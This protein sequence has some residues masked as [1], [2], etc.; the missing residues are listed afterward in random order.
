MESEI[1]FSATKIWQKLPI[2]NQQ[3]WKKSLKNPSMF[4]WIIK[5]TNPV[6]QME[7]PANRY[8]LFFFSHPYFFFGGNH[9]TAEGCQ[10]ESLWKRELGALFKEK[11]SHQHAV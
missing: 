1:I 5:H 8:D 3:I 6:M 7:V 4:G 2:G 11:F 10:R 9:L